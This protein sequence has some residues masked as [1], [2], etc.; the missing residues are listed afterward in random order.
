MIDL[1]F[2]RSFFPPAISKESRF[3]RYM[4]K[5]YLQ[6]LILDHLANTCGGIVDCLTN[7]IST[8]YRIVA[9][10]IYV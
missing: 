10:Y 3:D 7:K 5:E 2:I 6:L 9:D 8:N 1:E 4:L